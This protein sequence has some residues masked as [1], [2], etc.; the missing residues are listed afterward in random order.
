MKR[1]YAQENKERLSEYK[2]EHY[3]QNRE[4][5]LARV[6]ANS[7]GYQEQKHEYDKKR[8]EE[9]KEALSVKIDCECGG[10]YTVMSK[11]KHLKT[12]LHKKYEESIE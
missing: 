9:R 6:K 10:C 11:A 2:K 4:R 12:K 5:I 8:Y 7:E 3:K 1:K